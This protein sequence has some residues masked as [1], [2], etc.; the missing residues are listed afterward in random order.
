MPILGHRSLSSLFTSQAAC[1]SGC[2][3]YEVAK[4]GSARVWCLAMNIPTAADKLIGEEAGNWKT[5][6]I[7]GICRLNIGCS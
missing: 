7:P 5:S 6:Q 4:K 1:A 2:R 3:S